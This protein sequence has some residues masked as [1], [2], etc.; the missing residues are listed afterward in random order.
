MMLDNIV[1]AIEALPD[2]SAARRAALDALLRLGLPGPHEEQWKYTDLSV[3]QTLAAEDIAPN[4]DTHEFP[5][6]YADGLDALNAALAGGQ[7]HR[8]IDGQVRLDTG[9]HGRYHLTVDGNAE[10]RL[11]D[12]GDTRFATCFIT[13]A[14][15]PGA[16][17]RLTRV[18]TASEAAHRITRIAISVAENARVDIVTIDLDARF[19]RHDLAVALD[20]PGATA[21][22]Y[23]LYAPAGA[24]H[25][26]HHVRV[27][28]RAA[29]CISRGYF[30]GLAFDRACAVFNG[31]IMVHPHA[32]KTDSELRIAN[33]LLSRKAQI[34]AKPELEIYADDVKCAH[35]ATFG[36]LDPTAL[37][38]LRTR[39]VPEAAARALLTYSFANEIFQHIHPPELRSE[40]TAKFLTRMDGG[41]GITELT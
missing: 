28:H 26:D 20:A 16:R 1:T 41:A 34:N 10:L 5:A 7:Q 31:R 38:Y 3:L 15:A 12:A 17:L 19:A 35:G 29:H 32:Q 37:F 2:V 39:G 6:D 8:P 22:L 36:R 33:L 4:P 23:G 18:L 14:L 40:I 11:E 24:T 21:H 9:R 27:D 13:L 30:R 25:L